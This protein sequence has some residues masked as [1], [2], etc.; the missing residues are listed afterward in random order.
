MYPRFPVSKLRFLDNG[1]IIGADLL[2]VQ[3]DLRSNIDGLLDFFK[4]VELMD[5]PKYEELYHQNRVFKPM[6]Q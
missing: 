4:Y 2:L 6:N 1:A 3:D 5:N